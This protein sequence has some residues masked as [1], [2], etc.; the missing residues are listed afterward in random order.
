MQKF[1]EKENF[2][3]SL[4]SSTIGTGRGTSSPMSK[5]RMYSWVGGER[6]ILGYKLLTSKETST[7]FSGGEVDLSDL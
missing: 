7:E 1:G 6:R 3:S 4:N 2:R 5:S